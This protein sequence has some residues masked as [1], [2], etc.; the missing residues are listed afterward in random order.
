MPR[1]AGMHTTWLVRDATPDPAAT[2]PQASDFDA[3]VLPDD[4]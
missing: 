4:A 2:H 1:T 3:I